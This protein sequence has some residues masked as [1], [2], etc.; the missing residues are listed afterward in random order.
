M[1]SP[2]EWSTV[3]GLVEEI[4]AGCWYAG[5]ATLEAH[6]A[7]FRADAAALLRIQPL[8]VG[9][10]TGVLRNGTPGVELLARSGMEEDPD[11]AWSRLLQRRGH[12]RLSTPAL[13]PGNRWGTTPGALL[14]TTAGDS[15]GTGTHTLT[16]GLE[17][18]DGVS[19]AIWLQR[20]PG[21]EAFSTTDARL[22]EQIMP[23][24]QRVLTL[25]EAV[26]D[27]SAR[28]EGAT[29][30]LNHSPTGIVIL[31]ALGRT[32]F[33]NGEAER[34]FRLGDGMTLKE[35]R[36]L[37]EDSRCRKLYES[38]VGRLITSG[39][40]PELPFCLLHV[41]RPSGQPPYQLC[42]AAR[43]D[44]KPKLRALRPA[45]FVYLRDLVPARPPAT[46]QLN[47]LYGLTVAEANL[48]QLLYQGRPLQD[49]A[50][51]LGI[52]LNTAKTHR[53]QAYRKMGV[54]SQTQLIQHLVIQYWGPNTHDE[55][56]TARQLH[57]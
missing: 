12:L 54:C 39:P 29:E 25:Q 49:A 4:Y 14:E 19:W 21:D 35:G 24:W 8:A 32:L 22:L 11:I 42:V 51:T 28:L 13:A 20:N 48:C 17:G 23:H 26:D 47:A 7:A 43:A 9:S 55:P 40:T 2:V 44:F 45:V 38:T 1:T 36:I 31:N 10:P 30:V 53:R 56:E 16:A 18:R 33:V 50:R 41:R 27:L 34:I 15:R 37:V 57:S 3:A 46:E 52:T 5:S 6:A